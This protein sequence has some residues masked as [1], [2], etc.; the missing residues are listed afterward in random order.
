MFTFDNRTFADLLNR[1]S[2]E[3]SREAKDTDIGSRDRATSVEKA[4]EIVERRRPKMPTVD[5]DSTWVDYLEIKLTSNPRVE[6]NFSVP[7][8]NASGYLINYQP[9]QE[10]QVPLSVGVD[11]FVFTYQVGYDFDPEETRER[12]ESDLEAVKRYFKELGSREATWEEGLRAEL[13]ASLRKHYS[14]T[15]AVA[16]RIAAMGYPTEDPGERT[17]S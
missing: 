8:E 12:F 17:N 1:V 2:Q 14:A 15:E 5:E 3:A 11:S 7:I 6:I 10:L 4:R 16:S 9:S 13:A